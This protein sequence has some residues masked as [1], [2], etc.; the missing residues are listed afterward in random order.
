MVDR[1]CCPATRLL[2]RSRPGLR[3]RPWSSR[4]SVTPTPDHGGSKSVAFTATLDLPSWFT[5]SGVAVAAQMTGWLTFEPDAQIFMQSDLTRP[6][7]RSVEILL[8]NSFDVYLKDV[9]ADQW[10][11][12]PENSDTSR[13]PLEDIVSAVMM[14]VLMSTESAAD[15]YDDFLLE[16]IEGGY[17]WTSEDNLMSAMTLT[18]N[19]E[20]QLVSFSLTAHD[21]HEPIKV[22]L[23]GH[24]EQYPTLTPPDRATLPGLPADYWD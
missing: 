9:L 15:D 3:N 7:S 12:L 21:G 14:S 17:R 18:F 10:Y 13:G 11:L 24:D 23:F 5:E 4:R 8:S 22:T 1:P 19:T 20:Y 2:R 6:V 16:P